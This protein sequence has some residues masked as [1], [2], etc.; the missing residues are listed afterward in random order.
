M[1]RIW[2]RLWDVGVTTLQACGD[3]GEERDCCCPVAGVDADEAFDALPVARAISDFFTGNREYTANLPRK[4]KIAVTGCLDDC[5]RVEIDDI[6]LWPARASDG[7]IGFNVLAVG[8][9]S[10]RR[11]SA[12]RRTSTSSSRPRPGRRALTGPSRRRSGSSATG[13]TAASPA[14]A[15]SSRSSAPR[16]GF[17][18]PRSSD[19]GFGVPLD[20][21]GRGPRSPRRYRGDHVGVHPREDGDGLSYVGCS[22]PVGPPARRRPG[23]GGLQLARDLRRRDRPS[24]HRP[25]L[26]PDGR[27]PTTRLDDRCWPSRSSSSATRRSPGPFDSVVSWLA[28]VPSSAGS[29]SS[30]PRSG[31]SLASWLGRQLDRDPGSS[32]VPITLGAGSL[33][34]ALRR[35]RGPGR[36]RMHFSGCS[37]SL[38]PAPDRRHRAPRGDVAQVGEHLEEAVDIGLAGA[39]SAPTPAFIDWSRRAAVPVDTV[40]ERAWSA[41]IVGRYAADRRPDETFHEWARRVPNDHPTLRCRSCRGPMRDDEPEPGREALRAARADER[42]TRAAG[43]GVVLGARGRG[44]RRRPLH[45]VR[46]LRGRVPFQ[47]ARRE[48]GHQ[49]PRA[50]EDVHGLLALLGL[51]PAGRAAL[52]GDLWPPSNV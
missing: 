42:D 43:Q 17:R 4:F 52:R 12:W 18:R 5:A 32:P 7:T 38:R 6:G 16:R 46:Y 25:E 11:G 26:R 20:V 45:P 8:G 49:P 24:R 35:C 29:P 39:R 15:T 33:E 23:R 41:L 27:C 22:V 2:Q 51:L 3:L 9:L 14:C 47:L 50:R 48:R 40:P 36:I 30:R 37:A 28:P 21:S 19:A 31:R 34:R 10:E 44:D 1:P 13:R